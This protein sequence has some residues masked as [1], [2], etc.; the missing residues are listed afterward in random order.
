M[1]YLT[2]EDPPLKTLERLR[3]LLAGRGMTAA[4]DR[5]LLSVRQGWNLDDP[6][7]QARLLHFVRSQRIEVLFIDP[8]RSVTG[9]TD[10]TYVE[11]RPFIQ[12]L[13]QLQRETGVVLILTHHD[14]KPQLSSKDRRDRAQRMSGGGLFSVVDAP[15]HIEKLMHEDGPC[16]LLVPSD[17]KFGEAPPSIKLR[18]VTD[19][20]QVA[21]RATWATTAATAAT[22]R[23][24]SQDDRLLRHFREHASQ[25]FSGRQ[26]AD[27]LGM[28]QSTVRM[29]LN[30]LLT[31]GL[32]QKR[33]GG[34]GE[35]NAQLWRVAGGHP[36]AEGPGHARRK[37]PATAASAH[38]AGPSARP[39]APRTGSR[40]VR[41]NA[42]VRGRRSTA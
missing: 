13:R 32:V 40:K 20:P 25:E 34:G 41:V 18:L 4:P 1:W 9:A 36:L 37:R 42:R 27:A 29:A 33:T 24:Q 38:P 15:I 3:A 10:K 12:F 8:L 26:L 21:T 22:E 5:L 2:E 31:A 16:C 11:L 28:G 35:K 19:H 23:G 7:H 14:T 17:Y 30:R 6:D 39:S